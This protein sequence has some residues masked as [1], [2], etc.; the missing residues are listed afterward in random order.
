VAK[1]SRFWGF[2]DFKRRLVI[3][4]GSTVYRGKPLIFQEK[5]PYEFIRMSDPRSE[6]KSPL[7]V[8]KTQLT[9]H[10][11]AQRIAFRRHNVRLQF[12]S[13]ARWNQSLTEIAQVHGFFSSQSFWKAGSGRKGSHCGWSLRSAEQEFIRPRAI[14]NKL[15]NC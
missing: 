4:G 12:R 14:W 2:H 5:I 1:T 6:S 7:P 8:P 10:P 15:E 11:L 3:A 9:F 13:F